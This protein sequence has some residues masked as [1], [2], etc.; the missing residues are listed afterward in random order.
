MASSTKLRTFSAV[1]DVRIKLTNSN[2]VRPWSSSIGTNWTKIRVAARIS[3]EDS[4]ASI[5]STPRFAFGICSGTSNIFMDA[6]T[7]HWCGVCS[8]GSVISRTAGPPAYYSGGNI[9]RAAKRIGS[10]LTIGSDITG[11]YTDVG[12]AV[13]CTT[14]NRQVICLD[15][16]KGNPDFTIGGIM[17]YPNTA[18]DISLAAYL[19]GISVATPGFTNHTQFAGVTLAIDE[20]TY[21]YFNAVNIA[22]DRSSPAIEIS[23]LNVVK[24][25]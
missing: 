7:V 15:I 19:S 8:D 12:L 3:I 25:A 10:T 21:G 16:T 17:K 18:A 14:Q 11:G 13:D 2:F 1:D 6:T 20:A 24:L 5:V 9:Y 4:G 23:D 22:W